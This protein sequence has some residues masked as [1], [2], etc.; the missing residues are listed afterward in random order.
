MPEDPEPLRV[1]ALDGPAGSGKSTVAR[2]TAQALGWRY[3]D[4]GAC[5]R[6]ATLAVLRD[7]VDIS[8][9]AA[10]LQ[11]VRGARIE[12]STDPR[13]PITKLGGQDVSDELRGPAVTAAV[14]AVSAIPEVRELMVALQRQAL[15]VEGAVAEG[16]D[17]GSVVAP[18]A[19]VK[20]YLDARPEVRAA[21]RA[22][23]S[24]AGLAVAGGL[25]P[26]LRAVQADLE[27]RDALDSGRAA[28]PLRLADD[29]AVLDTSDLTSEEVVAAIVQR[30]RRAGLA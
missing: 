7:G 29:A 27:R 17:V 15:G 14:S 9:P 23:D 25:P 18:A 12:L 16:R 21:R 22:A 20:I 28:S 5:Y 6:A 30:V 24:D 8:Q 26:A 1:V 3:V 19:A 2:A 11:V 4:T 13:S 10:V